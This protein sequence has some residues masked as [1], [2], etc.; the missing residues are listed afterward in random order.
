MS[1]VVGIEAYY[2]CSISQ[3]HRYATS[4]RFRSTESK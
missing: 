3:I 4:E 2:K 1:K